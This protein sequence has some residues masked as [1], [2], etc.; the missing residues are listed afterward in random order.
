MWSESGLRFRRFIRRAWCRKHEIWEETSIYDPKGVWQGL[1]YKAVR[2][3][4]L[5]P[6]WITDIYEYRD[7]TDPELIYL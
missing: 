6:F 7:R 1:D 5:I 4:I 3:T 2:V